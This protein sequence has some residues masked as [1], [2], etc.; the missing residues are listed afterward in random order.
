MD[1]PRDEILGKDPKI[2][3]EMV[4]LESFVRKDY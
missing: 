3:R 1:F 4:S 2:P